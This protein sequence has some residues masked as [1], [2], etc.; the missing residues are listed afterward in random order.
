VR[1]KPN[2]QAG[3]YAALKQRWERVRAFERLAYRRDRKIE[4]PS[5]PAVVAFLEDALEATKADSDSA[6][7][8]RAIG[9]LKKNGFDR[10]DAGTWK[11][12]YA[13]KWGDA[14]SACVARMD[15]LVRHQNRSVRHAAAQAAAEFVVAGNTFEAVIRRL[16]SAYRRQFDN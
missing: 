11:R 1:A 4:R 2:G 7:L 5:G 16:S 12:A 9:H 8:R 3:Y 14:D 6:Y 13:S 15:Y 10:A